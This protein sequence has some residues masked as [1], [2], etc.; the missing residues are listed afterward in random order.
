VSESREQLLGRL[1]RRAL[2]TPISLGL[3]TTA[4]LCAVVPATWSVAAIAF[5]AEALVLQLLIRDPNFVRSVR[6][7]EQLAERHEWISR[8]DRARQVVDRETAE[9][10]GRIHALQD[11]L[12]REG[13]GAALGGA[14][15]DSRLHPLVGLMDRCVNLA[16]KRSHLRSYLQAVRPA[17]LQRQAGQ[18]EAKSA[19]ATDPVTRHLYAQALEQ[20]RGELES[21][22]A[23]QHAVERIDGQLE[24]IECSLSNLL[25]RVIRLKS[26]DDAHALLAQQQLS[27]ELIDLGAELAA[28][29]GSVNEMLTHEARP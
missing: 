23:I 5:L 22:S 15:A 14:L 13:S 24:S 28:L 18:L 7:D 10:L 26:A 6:E 17:D 3:L 8:I 19:G 20:K 16:G 2:V 9:L 27:R 12:L 1:A 29:E 11:R 4:C 25:G 21:Y